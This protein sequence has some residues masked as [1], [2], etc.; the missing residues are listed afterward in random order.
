MSLLL[1]CLTALTLGLRHGLD[2]D[3]FAAM[4]DMAGTAATE[5]DPRV[6]PAGSR[7]HRSWQTIKLPVLYILG[8]ALML[9]GLGVAALLFGAVV[10]DW[11]DTIM[12]RLV[13]IT[14]LALS[15]YLLYS[16][17]MF[18]VKG[19]EVQL[20]SRWMLVFAG[21]QRMWHWFISKL[22]GRTE[23]QHQHTINWDARGAF[24][25]GVIHGFGAETGTQ[26]LLFASIAG[27]ANIVVGLSMLGAFTVGMGI[28]TLAI[29][30]AVSYGL[31]QSAYFKPLVVVLGALAAIFSL[32]VGLYFTFGYSAL[33]PSF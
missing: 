14:L 25:V 19:T 12:E 17:A 4:L 30:I 16:L 32:V 3:H 1:I 5:T 23:H 28:S 26:V 11:L 31:T 10:P 22:T 9:F 27:T 13:G 21:A 2:I 33:L 29:A 20:R 18:F 6:R 24:W 8:H 15:A 7:L